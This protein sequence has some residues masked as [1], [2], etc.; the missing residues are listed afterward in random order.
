MP[1]PGTTE[2]RALVQQGDKKWMVH[3]KTPSLNLAN[4]WRRL[5]TKKFSLTLAWVGPDGKMIESET[6][7]R[8]KAPDFEGFKEPAVD[9]AA[10][11]DRNIAYLIDAAEQAPAPSREPGVPVWIWS[12]SPGY[13]LS[14]PCITINHLAWA[15][16][17]H[18]ENNGPQSAEALRLARIGAD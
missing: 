18:I 16:L 10:A 4:I 2:Y 5:E 13:D 17:A 7:E 1:L 11:A 14:Y 9:W 6:S 3:S 12:A 15:F 8:V